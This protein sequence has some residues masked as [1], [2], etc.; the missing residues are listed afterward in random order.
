MA[1]INKPSDINKIWADGG[2]KVSPSDVKIDTGWEVEVPPRQFFNWLDNKQ[3]QFNAHVNQHGI[4]VWDASTEYQA[5]KS[6]VQGNDGLIYVAVQTHS[7]QN[8]TTDVSNTYWFPYQQH[9][10]IVFSSAGVTNWTVPLAMQLGIIKPKVTITGGGGTVGTITSSAQNT[11]FGAYMTA[12]GGASVAGTN[13]NGANGG[14]ATGGAINI[15]GGS[16]GGAVTISGITV[17]G[18]GGGSYWGSSGET[19]SGSAFGA[20][21]GGT[22]GA[23]GSAGAGA[24][25]TAIGVIDLTGVTQV[26]ITVGAGGLNS[27]A[28]SGG[29]G[30]CQIEW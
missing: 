15:Q 10:M 18:S 22:H 6:Y 9:G 7:N 5:S 11:T 1:E 13:L 12:G 30:V 24:G 4:A 8:P 14:T 19:R 23:S 3:D 26:T 21:V 16:G 2:D 28:G 27:L 17:G 25:A 29:S 20:G